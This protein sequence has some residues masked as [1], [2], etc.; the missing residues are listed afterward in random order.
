MAF[1]RQSTAVGSIL[2]ESELTVLASLC[3]DRRIPDFYESKPEAVARFCSGVTA[4]REFARQ[5]AGI[6][7]KLTPKA[8]ASKARFLPTMFR[9]SSRAGR[10][11]VRREVGN[12]CASAHMLRI[13]QFP[14]LVRAQISGSVDAAA[15]IAF[16]A[17]AW[18]ETHANLLHPSVAPWFSRQFSTPTAAQAQAW[19]AIRAGEHVLIAAPTGS[20]KTLAA[21]L[22]AIDSLIRQGV[23]GALKDETQIVYVSPLKALSNDTEKNLVASPLLGDWLM[24]PP[25]QLVLDLPKRCPHAIAPRYPLHEELPTAVAFTDEGKAEEVEGC[26][27]SEPTLSTSICRKAAEFDQAS[28]VRIERQRE[29]LEPFAHAYGYDWG[30]SPYSSTAGN[31][32]T[33]VTD[34]GQCFC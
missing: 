28:L 7:A 13:H 22:A 29:L 2:V 25:S 23:K 33:S 11:S 1:T 31:G 16:W 34:A 32:R 10:Y 17:I 12:L 3:L 19:P 4:S 9:P 20:G 26:R 21:F 27:L 6:A 5:N 24:H 15:I 14:A 30:C 18:D 8:C